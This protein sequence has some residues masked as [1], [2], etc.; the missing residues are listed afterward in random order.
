MLT[1]EIFK[2]WMDVEINDNGKLSKN[3]SYGT[4]LQFAIMVKLLR[5]AKSG[6]TNL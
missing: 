6:S 2:S 4:Y 1:K 5:L 3:Y